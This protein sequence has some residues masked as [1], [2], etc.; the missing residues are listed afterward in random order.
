[1][2]AEWGLS[3]HNRRARY[4]AL[5]PAGRRVIDDAF[6]AHVRNE[7]RL[8]A[9]LSPAQRGDLERLLRA[10]GGALEV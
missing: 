4:Y 5:T 9:G 3:E 10:W 1:M 6:A 7:A 8:L 2:S